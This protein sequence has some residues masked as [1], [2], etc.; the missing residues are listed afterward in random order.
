VDQLAGGEERVEVD[1]RPGA[2]ELLRAAE[3][4]DR[5]AWR[6]LVAR[7][8]PTV[9]AVARSHRLDRHDAADVV[10]STWLSLLENMNRIHDPA[11]LAAWLAVTARR[12]ALRLIGARRRESPVDEQ[13]L[14]FARAD[15]AD[16]AVLRS[17][18]NAA[19]WRAFTQLSEQ[20]QRV[21]RVLVHAPELSYRQVAA[22]LGI[23]VGSIG[24]TRGRCLA[25][26]RRK[27]SLSGLFREDAG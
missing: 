19:L 25:Q 24:P 21:L 3:L 4:G 17:S 10:Q 18:P 16:V 20:C 7:H 13:R 8:T 15:A 11:A 27:A 12:H 5:A 22:S 9:W 1:T 23:P 6:E 14:D 2:A 26:L